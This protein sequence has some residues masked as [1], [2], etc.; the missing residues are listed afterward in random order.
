[1]VED[2]LAVRDVEDS[3]LEAH[4]A[5]G[6][7][8]ELEVRL[9]D[10]R[11]HVAHGSAGVAEDL[12]DLAGVLAR[13]LDHGLLDGLETTAVRT[14]LEE[15]LRSSDLELEALAPHVLHED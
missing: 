15:D 2:G 13:T 4:D 1:M 12:D 3:V 5:A 6:R 7:D 11:L 9:G 8:L 10:A 14:L